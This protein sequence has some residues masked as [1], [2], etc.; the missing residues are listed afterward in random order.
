MSKKWRLQKII[1]GAQEGA[2]RAGL[3]AAALSGFHTGGTAPRGYKTES[4]PMPWLKDFGVVE[5][6][7]NGYPERTRKNVADSDVTIIFSVNR[8]S[9]GTVCTLK[10]AHDLKKPYLVVN[11]FDEGQIPRIVGFLIENHPET[12]NI[13]GNRESVAPGIFKQT[14]SILYSLLANLDQLTLQYT[15]EQK[16]PVRSIQLIEEE[17]GFLFDV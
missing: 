16:P 17:S 15:Q 5:S 3:V 2:D 13:A 6:E 1:S 4:G 14:V 12:V 8:N 10:C 11:P 7:S 9:T